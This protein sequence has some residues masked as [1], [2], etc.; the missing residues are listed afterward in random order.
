MTRYGSV[1]SGK[2]GLVVSL[3]S[4]LGCR[5]AEPV[6]RLPCSELREREAALGR[7]DVCFSPGGRC[8]DGILA[9]LDGAQKEVLVQD[10]SFTSERIA[11]A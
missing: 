3:T 6:A 5:R 7:I 10:Y 1:V 2:W 8:V 4:V 11:G 9:A